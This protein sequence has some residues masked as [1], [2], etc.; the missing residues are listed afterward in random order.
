MSV[1]T[2][3]GDNDYARHNAL[4][5]IIALFSSEYSDLALERLD[6]EDAEFTRIMEAVSSVPLLASKKMVLLSNPSKN[7]E[8]GERINDLLGAVIDSTELVVYEPKFD[9]RSTLFKSLKKSSDF[10]DF[11]NLDLPELTKWLVS[12][13]RQYGAEL[14]QPEARYLIERVGQNQQLLASEAEKLSLVGGKISRQQIT[15]MTEAT[16][17][18]TIFQLL[19]AALAGKTSLAIEIFDEQRNMKVEPQQIIGMFAWQLHIMALMKTAGK[20][21]ADQVAREAKISPY[22]A[23]KTKTLVAN[24]TLGKLVQILDNLLDIDRRSKRSSIDLDDALK[25]FI[26]G[27]G[28]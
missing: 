22:V 8:V 24:M 13:V 25:V 20:R 14:A 3:T 18:S 11:A 4:T 7:K 26:I 1:I 5:E 28:Q 12:E 23:G 2:L 15:D 9:K 16:P 17:Q 6:G 21:S 19:D 10:R 27:L